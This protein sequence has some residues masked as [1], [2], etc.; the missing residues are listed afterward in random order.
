MSVYLKLILI[1]LFLLW[2]NF[3]TGKMMAKTEFNVT[4]SQIKLTE[5]N[6]TYSQIIS[7]VKL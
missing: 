4:Y 3:W 2:N 1:P 6:V 7:E 5:F